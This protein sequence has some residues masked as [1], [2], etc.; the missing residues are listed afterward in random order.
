MKTY[1]MLSQV[2]YFL[3]TGE[4]DTKPLLHEDC[5]GIGVACSIRPESFLVRSLKKNPLLSHKFAVFALRHM[6]IPIKIA[7][8]A[9]GSVLMCAFHL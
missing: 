8:G 7:R 4:Q 1:L 6:M 9:E 2:Q 3:H 5:C